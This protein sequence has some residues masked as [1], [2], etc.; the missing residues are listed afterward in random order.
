MISGY[1]DAGN[2]KPTLP[3]KRYIN[4]KNSYAKNTSQEKTG[5]EQLGKMVKFLHKEY[6]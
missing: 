4:F 6:A 1:Q 2:Y 3:Q 5:K